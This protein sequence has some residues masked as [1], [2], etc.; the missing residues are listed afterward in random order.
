MNNTP[1]WTE[2]LGE[3]LCIVDIDTRALNGSGQILSKEG[4]RWDDVEYTG[5]GMLNHYLYGM[6][7]FLLES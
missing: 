2:S 5:A 6:Y 7:V 1:V 4:F 3:R